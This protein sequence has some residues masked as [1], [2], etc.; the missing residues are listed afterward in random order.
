MIL[1]GENINIMNKKIKEAMVNR[2]KELIQKIAV[3]SKN[4]GMHYL[5]LNIGPARK[6]GPFLIEWLIKAI[7][8]VC[9]LP[10]S[11]D[12]TNIEALKVGLEMEGEKAIINSIQ[13]VEERME[14]LLPLVKKYN[15]KFIGLL[16][17]K[18]GMPRDENER[19]A[20]AANFLAKIDEYGISH[21]KVYFDPIVL[22]VRFQ[23]EQVVATLEFMKMFKELFPDCNSTCGL[24]N[25]SNGALNELRGLLNRTYLVMLWKYGMDSAIVDAYDKEL[26]SIINHQR[27]DIKNLIWKAMDGEIDISSLSEHEKNYVKTVYVLQGKSI[28]S[29]SYLKL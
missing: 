15:C 26:V 27:E 23:Q 10:L 7:R 5:D 1:I 29:D 18:E 22:P 20:I 25:V 12:T 6:D 28:Y 9:D 8:E 13:G 16:L 3:E 4:N 11:I 2:K 14:E 19:G 24:S 17:S 21:D